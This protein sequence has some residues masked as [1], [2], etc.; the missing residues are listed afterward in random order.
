MADIIAQAG[1]TTFSEAEQVWRNLQFRMT[2]K[3]NQGMARQQMENQGL[4]RQQRSA[5]GMENQGLERQQRSAPR[6]ENQEFLI[7][8][9]NRWSTLDQ[10][11]C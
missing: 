2:R 10:E 7:P 9:S 4:Q 1:L 11:N 5:P 8:T 3:P 6:M